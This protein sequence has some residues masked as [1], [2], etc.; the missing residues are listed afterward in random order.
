MI[1]QAVVLV[2][3]VGGIVLLSA[4]APDQALPTFEVASVKPR[5]L[6]GTSLSAPQGARP[7]GAFGM[8]NS[9][10]ARLV[11]YAYDRPDYQVIGGP[12][13]VR[14]DRFDIAARAGREAS[15]PD[16]RLMLQSLLE[17]RF[18]LRTHIEQREMTLYK[19]VMARGDGRL[20]PNLTKSDD[21]CKRLV[22]RPPNV[23]A[24]AVTV[25]GCSTVAHLARSASQVMAAP[26]TDA[27]GLAGEFEYAFYY[28]SGGDGLVAGTSLSPDINAPSFPTALQERL[29]LKLEST[30]GPAEVLVIDSVERPTPD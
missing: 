13:W 14:T 15:V 25:T 29:G 20:G 16:I 10:V 9:T 27:T 24:G 28:S 5:T 4:H 1:R 8:V 19:L 7:G 26:V 3:V 11:M 12:A 6:P 30:R 22:Q 23:P 18:K 21:S 2:V 17:S